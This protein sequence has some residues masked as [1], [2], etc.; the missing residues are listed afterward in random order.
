MKTVYLVHTLIDGVY[1]HTLNC[2]FQ[3]KKDAE[4]VAYNGLFERIIQKVE[5]L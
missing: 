1:D 2:A 3:R 4:T 5:V